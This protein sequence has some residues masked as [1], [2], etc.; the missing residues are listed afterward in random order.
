MSETPATKGLFSQARLYRQY[1]FCSCYPTKNAVIPVQRRAKSARY[2]NI[3]RL[4]PLGGACV[5]P[6]LQLSNSLS[7]RVDA[8]QYTYI[9]NEIERVLHVIC[10]DCTGQCDD[11]CD[12]IRHR[13]V[14]HKT[15]FNPNRLQRRERHPFLILLAFSPRFFSHN[16]HH[17]LVLG[18]PRP[19]G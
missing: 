18:R 1:P 7:I 3:L 9:M 16:V 13:K 14:P 10:H 4:L 2:K 5:R 15:T 17:Q 8:L 6:L 19:I 12:E 11:A